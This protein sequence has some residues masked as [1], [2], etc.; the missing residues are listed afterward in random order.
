MED[1]TL[2]LMWKAE[3]AD[4]DGVIQSHRSCNGVSIN[5]EVAR[6]VV[7]MLMDR[8]AGRLPFL[9]AVVIAPVQPDEPGGS[10]H[11]TATLRSGRKM[12]FILPS[13][14]TLGDAVKAMAN[15]L[16]RPSPSLQS[17]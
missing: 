4:Q 3:K 15:M 2:R 12:T 1:E 9:Q 8:Y 6:L 16:L 14:S 10:F 7:T 11:V 17:E 5:S 13:E